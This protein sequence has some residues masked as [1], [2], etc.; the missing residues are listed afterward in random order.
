MRDGARVNTW[1]ISNEVHKGEALSFLAS[2]MQALKQET[3]HAQLVGQHYL[4]HHTPALHHLELSQESS[5]TAGA[6]TFT[7]THVQVESQLHDQPLQGKQQCGVV[8]NA[9]NHLETLCT[10]GP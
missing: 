8:C 10:Q 2:R 9:P 1:E 3:T 7:S 4:V 6:C 5:C